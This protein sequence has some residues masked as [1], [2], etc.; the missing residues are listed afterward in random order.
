MLKEAWGKKTRKRTRRK[1]RRTRRKRRRTRRRGPWGWGRGRT[2]CR[3]LILTQ[4]QQAFVVVPEGADD[5][6]EPLL[7]R[8]QKLRGTEDVMSSAYLPPSRSPPPSAPPPSCL[9]YLTIFP[10]VRTFSL[11]PSSTP[12]L[13]HLSSFSLPSPLPSHL[14]TTSL[15]LSS[16]CRSPSPSRM[17]AELRH[18]R[19]RVCSAGR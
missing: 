3:G 8:V 10:D 11:F 12:F 14:P 13:A 16:P 19:L 6:L 5:L 4:P 18:G 2:R 9:A 7:H 1:R 17:T 15:P